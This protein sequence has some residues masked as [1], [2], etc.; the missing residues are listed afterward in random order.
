MARKDKKKR[1]VVGCSESTGNQTGITSGHMAEFWRLA[2]LSLIDGQLMSW[3][4][5]NIAKIRE[6]AGIKWWDDYVK[7]EEKSLEAFFGKKFDL[8]IFGKTL[9]DCGIEQIRHW[10]NR[11]FEIHFLPDISMFQ[12][13]EYRGWRIKPEDWY[14]Q[15]V[16]QGKIFLQIDDELKPVKQVKLNGQVVL[17]DTRLKPAYKNGKQMFFQ[18]TLIGGVIIKLREQESIARYD[19]GDQTSR[20]GVSAK[21]WQEQIRP[22]LAREFGVEINKVRLETAVEANVIPQLYPYMP[23]KDDG[24]TNT[25]VWYEECFEDVS[26]RLFGGNSDYGGL[27]DVDFY[28]VGDHWHDR[29]FRPLVVLA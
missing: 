4:L 28:S 6:M 25:R 19:H 16:A 26:N 18:D 20:F 7:K 21:E 27:S 14:Y 11:G 13:D 10:Q 23:R 22:A 15:Q 17:I 8:S 9:R 29:S 3:I 2:G 5:D 1:I 12:A 24:T